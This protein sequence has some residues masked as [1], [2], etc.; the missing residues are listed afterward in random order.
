MKNILLISFALVLIG[1]CD[2]SNPAAVDTS[3]IA[4]GCTATACASDCACGCDGAGGDNCTCS[5][6]CA[7]ASTCT[8]GGCTATGCAS[9]C[10]CGCDGVTGADGCTC[11]T[12]CAC[13]N[14][15]G[16]SST[17]NAV[18]LDG[19]AFS[20]STLTISIGETVT[21]TLTNGTHTVVSDDGAWQS[22]P[23]SIGG[24]FTHQFD[25]AGT[26]GYKCGIHSGMTGTIIVQ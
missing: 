12:N 25:A 3:C 16:D 8:A 24:T 18:S 11:A 4:G 17:S 15:D 5:T 22:G 13:V 10:A 21:W 14:D 2:N 9:D 6:N 20:P 7:C 19:F 23:L 1:A 26:F